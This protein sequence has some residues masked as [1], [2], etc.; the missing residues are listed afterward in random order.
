MVGIM[1]EVILFL[2]SAL[3]IVALIGLILAVSAGTI[4]GI[5][6]T[7]EEDNEAD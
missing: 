7:P 3:I 2:G 5:F 4:K 6:K 1:L